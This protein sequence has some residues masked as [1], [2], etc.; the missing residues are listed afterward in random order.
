M[1]EKMLLMIFL[2]TSPLENT[3]IF[4]RCGSIILTNLF[5]AFP[6]SNISEHGQDGQGDYKCLGA[7]QGSFIS[8][9]TSAM[10]FYL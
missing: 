7:S 5:P 2:L 6:F 8:K 1:A 3:V 4:D 9:Q 10:T